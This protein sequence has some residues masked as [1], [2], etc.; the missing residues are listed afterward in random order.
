MISWAS[1]QTCMWRKQQLQI[2]LCANQRADV[3]GVSVGCASA[4][5]TEPTPTDLIAEVDEEIEDLATAAA[6]PLECPCCKN[7]C[8]GSLL[9]SAATVRRLEL[10][11][12]LDLHI[13]CEHG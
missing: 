4:T 11:R 1:D 6:L 5:V 12:A 13:F 9:L 7:L 2:R 3:T 8:S 10:R